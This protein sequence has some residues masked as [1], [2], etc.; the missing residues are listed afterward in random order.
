M[1][2]KIRL[3]RRGRKKRPVYDVVV[4][5]ARAKRD[6]KFIEKLGQYNPMVEPASISIDVDKAFDW[7]M[8]GA[9]P[10]DTAR[11]VLSKAGVMYRK[12]LAGG[13]SKGAFT[14]EEAD[15]KYEAFM[16]ERT[17]AEE[18]RTNDAIKAQEA[19]AKAYEEAKAKAVDEVLAKKK[20]AEQA[21]IDEVRKQEEA[22]AAEAAGTEVEEEAPTEEAAPEAEAAPE[23]A[24][25]AEKTEGAAE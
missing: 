24:P 23:E 4:A 19:K 13:V 25:A 16:G 1:A 6:G 9:Q 18:S 22:A 20:A 7:V 10:T 5:D 3:A 21:L 8:K 17:S 15:K 14:Q 11:T 2:V 12:H